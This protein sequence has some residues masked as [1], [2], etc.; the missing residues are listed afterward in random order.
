[1]GRI[2]MG[3]RVGIREVADAAGVS[4]ATVSQALNGKGRISA[5]T[6]QSVREAARALGFV[7]DR[8]ASRMR[9]GRSMLIGLIVNDIANS[10]FAELSSGVETVATEHGYLSVMAD[11][12]DDPERQARLIATM[13]AQGVDGLIISS[14]SEA[15]PASLARLC[16][17][18]VPYVLCVRDVDDPTAPFVGFD[19]HAAG[20]LAAGH[21]IARGHARLA[22]LGATAGNAN[23]RRR[24][25]GVRE[26]VEDAGARLVATREG[27]ANRAFGVEA[28][29]DVL[30]GQREATA[31]LCFNDAVALGVYEGVRAAGLRVGQDVAVMG[32]DNVSESAAW[33]PPLT[34]V[35]L[36]PRGIGRQAGETLLRA[37]AD[38]ESTPHRVLLRPRLV[39]RASA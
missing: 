24:L 34:T 33:E 14:A 39:E 4:T 31:L 3:K 22:F 27:P 36:H 19:N 38:G 25:A 10:F 5:E 29:R 26:A 20:R 17:A 13:T 21:L 18:G 8:G 16:A 11:S 6:R 35:E 30:G 1:M 37:I 12:H 32:F 15:D 28:A 2:G 23:R 7:A 9:S